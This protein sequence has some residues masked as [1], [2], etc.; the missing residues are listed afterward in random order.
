MKEIKEYTRVTDCIAPFLGLDK[1]DKAVL[2]NAAD[3]GSVVHKICDSIIRGFGSFGLED[4]VCVYAKTPDQAEKEIKLVTNLVASFEAWAAGKVFIKKPNRFFNDE[5]MITG[6]C[7]MLYQ[8]QWGNLILVD[9]KTS[10]SKSKS[11]QVQGSAYSWMAKKEGIPIS[12]IEFVHL[13]RTGIAPVSHVFQEDFDL[14]KMTLA[15]Y[16]YWYKDIDLP[17]EL[18]YL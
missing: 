18:E 15:A 2:Q 7:D 10:Q 5:Y 14:F 1:I 6:D 17:N 4:A 13:S 9:L 8:D 11:W 3:R 12:E 16:R